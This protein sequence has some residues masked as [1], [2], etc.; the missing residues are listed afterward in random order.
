MVPDK[1]GVVVCTT[2]HNPHQA[3]VFPPDSVLSFRAMKLTGKN[4]VASPVRGQVWC[5]HCH[6][7]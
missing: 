3:G 7:F 6:D 4:S 5:R 2:C 1:N